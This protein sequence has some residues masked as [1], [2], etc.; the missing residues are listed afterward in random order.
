VQADA[1]ESGR[2]FG[3]AVMCLAMAFVTCV[4]ALQHLVIALVAEPIAWRRWPT[5]GLRVIGLFVV[6]DLLLW[7]WSLAAPHRN[8]SRSLR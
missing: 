4:W 8:T 1:L 5:P 2:A 7:G 3:H 6:V